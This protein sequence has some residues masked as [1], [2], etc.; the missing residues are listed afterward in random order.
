MVPRATVFLLILLLSATCLRAQVRLGV[1]AGPVLSF[2]RTMSALDNLTSSPGP[3]GFGTKLN[4]LVFVPLSERYQFVTGLNYMSKRRSLRFN[5]ITEGNPKGT[6]FSE[7]HRLQYLGT[8]SVLR[9]N[10][11]DIGAT[12]G[13]RLFFEVGPQFYVKLYEAPVPFNKKDAIVKD[14]VPVDFS[15]SANSGVE[16]DFGV[17]TSLFAGFGYQHLL[18][19]MD[20][21]VR[22]FDDRKD[23]F[24]RDG[25]FSL[26]VGVKF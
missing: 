1:S 13:L 6:D 11:D 15:I 8:K 7:T 25:V 12:L 21:R 26:L 23:L 16:I 9:L 19:E 10:T 2:T 20:R 4:F 5:A 17:E 22:L 14:F 18:H 24:L 3:L